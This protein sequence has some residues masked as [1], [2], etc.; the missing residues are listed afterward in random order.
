MAAGRFV[1]VDTAKHAIVGGPYLWDPAG[2]PEWVAPE[3]AASPLASYVVLS[4]DDAQ[5]A[6]HA[7]PGEPYVKDIGQDI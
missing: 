6:G 2:A 7:W 1:V 3:I 5:A 4:E